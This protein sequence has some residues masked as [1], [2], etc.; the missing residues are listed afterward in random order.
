MVDHST[1]LVVKSRIE[2]LVLLLPGLPDRFAEV[3]SP[4][5]ISE[6]SGFSQDLTAVL[7]TLNQPIVVGDDVVP[8]EQALAG[9]HDLQEATRRFRLMAIRVWTWL[10]ILS[11]HPEAERDWNAAPGRAGVSPAQAELQRLLSRC[12]RR[13]CLNTA[14]FSRLLRRPTFCGAIKWGAIAARM[15][16][17]VEAL[18]TELLSAARRHVS[19]APQPRNNTDRA[20][21]KP[22]SWM[23]LRE[24]LNH[25]EPGDPEAM[26]NKVESWRRRHPE[27]K[28]DDWRR[29]TP[30]GSGGHRFEYRY[31]AVRHL[32]ESQAP[33]S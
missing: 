17:E 19:S 14:A 1:K 9:H 31:G 5:V 7:R 6:R 27:L 33:D 2:K 20:R 3:N 30:K 10:T 22:N 28:N 8:F 11:C 16:S 26:R 23:P 21:P 25:A 12:E 18:S 13:P 24:L 32:I 15:A 4:Y 29:V